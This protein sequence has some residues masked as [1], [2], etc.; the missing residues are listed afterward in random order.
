MGQ[1]CNC[2]QAAAIGSLDNVDCAQNF[3]Q[4]QKAAFQRTLSDAG[5]INVISDPTLLATW[6]ALLAAT[7]GTKV[8]ITPY[9]NAPEMEAGAARTYG[10]GNDTLDGIEQIVGR[11]PTSFT[12][13]LNGIPQKVVKQLKAQACETMSVFYFD[14]NGLIQLINS[15]TDETPVYTGI[16]IAPKTY[17]VGDMMNGGL[18][19]PDNN[20]L[21][22]QHKPNWSDDVVIVQ[23]SDFN[24][25]TDLLNQ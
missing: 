7:D 10:G 8:V 22:W 21:T 9:I 16:P 24:P 14:E 23:P 11:E 5:A 4:I 13:A 2:P 17:F 18:E 20:A 3:G 15:G 12:S 1:V 6:T 19:N 25:L